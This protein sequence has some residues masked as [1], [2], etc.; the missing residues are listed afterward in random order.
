VAPV[1][2]TDKGAAPCVAE[3]VFGVHPGG[4]PGLLIAVRLSWTHFSKSDTCI[5][6]TLL[7]TGAKDTLKYTILQQKR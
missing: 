4:V 5:E 6:C 2:V 1:L 7:C 3:L